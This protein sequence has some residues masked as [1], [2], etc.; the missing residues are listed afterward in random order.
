MILAATVATGDS[1]TL[2]LFILT[3]I[4]MIVFVILGARFG[5]LAGLLITLIVSIA[6]CVMLMVHYSSGA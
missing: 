3:T 2:P 5:G 1:A 4:G 6:I